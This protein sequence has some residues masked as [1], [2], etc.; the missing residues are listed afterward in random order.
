MH[1]YP[2]KNRKTA[3]LQRLT[4]ILS[5]RQGNLMVYLVVVLLI[6]GVLGVTIVSLYSTAK[7]SAATANDARRA[8]YLA[9]SGIRYAL[10]EVR[11]SM[12]L[13]YAA[14]LLNTTEYKVDRS[15][16]FRANV[17]SPGL[18]VSSSAGSSWTLNVPYNGKFPEDFAVQDAAANLFIVDWIRFKGATPDSDSYA[19]RPQTHGEQLPSPSIW[20]GRTISLPTPATGSVSPFKR[21]WT[22]PPSP[23]ANPF[24]WPRKPSTFSH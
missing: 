3:Y 20:M 21:R 12:D 16:S 9:E 7:G 1:T 17:F 15:G 13:E 14:T 24:T 23:G 19:A 4:E 5:S 2:F 8:L 22:T 18:V 10:S 11:N 6:F